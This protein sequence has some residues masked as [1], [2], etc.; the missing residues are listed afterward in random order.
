[1]SD[2]ALRAL[3]DRINSDTAFREA[4]HTGDARTLLEEYDLSPAEV[5]ALLAND[6]DALRRLVGLGDVSGYALSI[7]CPSLLCFP[8]QGRLGTAAVYQL[9][10]LAAFS[11]AGPACKSFVCLQ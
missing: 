4:L 10:S 3:L 6:E 5:V 8:A 2:Q 1:M 11:C 9:V 7:G